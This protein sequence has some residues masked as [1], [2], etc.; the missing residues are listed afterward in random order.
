MGLH[1]TAHAIERYQQRVADVTPAEA[2]AALSTPAFVKAAEIGACAVKLSTG[3]RAVIENGCV[4]T[5]HPKKARWSRRPT[6]NEGD[7]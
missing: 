4:V 3:H 6:Q 2:R 1:V 7:E 5:V